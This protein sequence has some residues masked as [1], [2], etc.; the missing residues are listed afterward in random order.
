MLGKVIGVPVNNFAQKWK[1]ALLITGTDSTVT[2]PVGMFPQRTTQHYLNESYIM[3]DVSN[4][5]TN[6]N[7]IMVINATPTM[8]NNTVAHDNHVNEISKGAVLSSAPLLSNMPSN[9]YMHVAKV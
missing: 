3:N 1:Q 4:N 6:I 5:N 9:L 2:S 8:K 7:N